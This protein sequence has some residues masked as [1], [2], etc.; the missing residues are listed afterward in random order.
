MA[1]RPLVKLDNACRITLKADAAYARGIEV[2]FVTDDDTFTVAAA[3]DP[4]AIGT[5]ERAVTAAGKKGDIILYGHAIVEVLVGTGGCTRGVDAVVVADGYTDA[6]SNGG[7]TTSQIIK[8]KFMQSGVA[9]DR[10]GLLIGVNQRSV[11][12]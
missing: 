12:A 3:N 10:V 6:A 8:G 2:K 1:K 7:G 9:L 5:L 4:L 11:K